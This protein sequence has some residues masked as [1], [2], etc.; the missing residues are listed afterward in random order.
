MFQAAEC[1]PDQCEEL[2]HASLAITACRCEVLDSHV[3][4]NHAGQEPEPSVGRLHRSLGKTIEV[5]DSRC[6][7]KD[8]RVQLL[9]FP[10]RVNDPH[11]RIVEE[12]FFWTNGDTSA[13][14]SEVVV[15]AGFE[16]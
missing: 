7:P 5:D 15:I 14:G 12:V 8:M 13:F 9:K 11:S 2:T 1:A 16:A 10:S 3:L 6:Q 4:K